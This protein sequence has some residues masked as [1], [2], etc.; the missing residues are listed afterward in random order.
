MLQPSHRDPPRLQG[1]AVVM[2][3]NTALLVHVLTGLL[4]PLRLAL[5]T[6]VMDDCLF[7]ERCAEQFQTPAAPGWH[8]R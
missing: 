7:T 8:D 5:H 2:L 1:F 4:L 3:S 6:M